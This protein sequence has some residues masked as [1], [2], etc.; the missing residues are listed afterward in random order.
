MITHAAVLFNINEPLKIIELE[1][2]KLKKGQVLVEIIYSGACGTQLGEISG[3]RGEDKFL[4]HCLGHEGVGKVLELGPEVSKVSMGEKVVL[5]WIKGSGIDAGGTV[6]KSE[7]LIHSYYVKK[8]FLSY[9][10][11]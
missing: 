9:Y 7:N 3:K 10:L 8:E 6:Y 11:R 4:P 1:I 5:S 2:P